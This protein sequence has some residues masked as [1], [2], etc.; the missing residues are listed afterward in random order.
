MMCLY[1]VSANHALELG[2]E[3]WS[4]RMA[5][6]NLEGINSTIHRPISGAYFFG[7]QVEGDLPLNLLLSR[8]S[9]DRAV[10]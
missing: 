8:C 7:R 10:S 5:S 6:V 4:S 9:S 2:R 3:L 1:T